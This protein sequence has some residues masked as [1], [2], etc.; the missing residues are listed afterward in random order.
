M[1][2]RCHKKNFMYFSGPGHQLP[3]YIFC[4]SIL[5][6]ASQTKLFPCHHCVRLL[7]D[8][9]KNCLCKFFCER[10]VLL[11]DSCV[12]LPIDHHKIFPANP[13]SYPPLVHLLL[14]HHSRPKISTHSLSYCPHTAPLLRSLLTR[15]STGSHDQ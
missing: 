7:I 4:K 1:G 2:A 9:H 13:T 6:A 14:H 10:I 8:R 5:W 15:L 11:N 12:G 3:Q